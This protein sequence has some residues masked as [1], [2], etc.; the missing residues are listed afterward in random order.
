MVSTAR[1]G[2]KHRLP[3]EARKAAI[4][5]CELR[6]LRA[7]QVQYTDQLHCVPWRVVAAWHNPHVSR[8]SLDDLSSQS[9]A[10]SRNLFRSA[11]ASTTPPVNTFIL[12]L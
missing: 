10:S 1:C 6:V 2:I 3:S 7:V 5:P 9:T 12:L 4:F 8:K 11:H